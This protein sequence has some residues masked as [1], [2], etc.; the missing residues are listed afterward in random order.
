VKVKT[1]DV[2]AVTVAVAAPVNFTVAP[3][4]PDPLIVPVIVKV[5]VVLKLAVLF[6]PLTVTAWLV[7]VKAKPALV[8][9][10]V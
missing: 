8:G 6:A 9:V 1:P 4:P 3:E 2:F 5:D 10:T 7:G